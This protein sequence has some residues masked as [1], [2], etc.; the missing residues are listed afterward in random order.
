MSKNASKSDPIPSPQ[1]LQS[2]PQEVL[3]KSLSDLQNEAARRETVRKEAERQAR[4]EMGEKILLHLGTLKEFPIRDVDNVF[5]EAKKYG[6]WN[7]DYQ[8]SI[9]VERAVPYVPVPG[10]DRW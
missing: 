8:I 6:V 7:E 9:V 10:R 3:E 2:L 1:D 4:I 5:E